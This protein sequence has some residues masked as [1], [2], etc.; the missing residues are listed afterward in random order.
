MA[1]AEPLNLSMVFLCLYLNL[2]PTTK[3]LVQRLCA[4]LETYCQD[5]NLPYVCR[6]SK[7]VRLTT[8]PGV[9]E[10]KPQKPISSFLPRDEWQR[11]KA[12]SSSAAAYVPPPGVIEV[13][14]SNWKDD[15][16]TKVR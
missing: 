4:Y 8:A 6:Q 13:V 10:K 9:K 11:M 12:S 15:Y 14:S 3:D 16:L 7:Q 1:L 5:N 2:T